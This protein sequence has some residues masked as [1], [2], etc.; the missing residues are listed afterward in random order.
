MTTY[1][2]ASIGAAASR[3]LVGS[4]LRASA[5][6]E[7]NHATQDLYLGTDSS[8][9]TANGLRVAALQSVRITHRG[10]VWAIASG[11]ATDVRYMLETV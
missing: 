2:N 9:T 1:G 8:V 5:L 6:I 10:E 7:N 11:A 3:L 4:G